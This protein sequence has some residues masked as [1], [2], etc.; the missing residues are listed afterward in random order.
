MRSPLVCVFC[1]ASIAAQPLRAQRGEF[2]AGVVAAYGTAPA[3]GPGAGLVLGVAPGRLAYLGLRWTYYFG[4]SEQRG[5]APTDVLTKA[6]VIGVD[7]GVEIPVGA[8]EVFPGVSVGW[9]Q[10]TQHASQPTSSGSSHEFFGAPGVAVELRI[11]RLGLIPELQYVW[12]GEPDIPWPIQHE[13]FVF[14]LRC[15]ILGEVRRIRR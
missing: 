12:A 13:G 11:A 14:S 4:V 9:N 3:Y 5:S 10:F 2:Q 15:V 8:V 1:V 7:L 6:Q